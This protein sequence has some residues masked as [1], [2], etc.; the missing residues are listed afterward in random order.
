MNYN[1][2]F[3]TIFGKKLMEYSGNLSR[4]SAIT[5]GPAAFGELDFFNRQLSES[6]YDLYL[7]GLYE[8]VDPDILDVNELEQLL[9]A[10]E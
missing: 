6:L 3:Y 2:N 7:I 5:L 4:Q 8:A 9:H 1:Y 10:A